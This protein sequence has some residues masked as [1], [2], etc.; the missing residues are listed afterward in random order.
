M[1]GRQIY[2]QSVYSSNNKMLILPW[3]KGFNVFNLPHHPGSWLITL[4]NGTISETQCWS[5]LLADWALSYDCSQLVLSDWKFILLNP[6]ITSISATMACLFINP[7]GNDKISWGKRLAFIHRTCYPTHLIIELLCWGHPLMTIHLDKNIFRL[8]CSVRMVYLHK[9]SS[10]F[11]VT[12][13][14]IRFL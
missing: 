2:T 12:N 14:S 3:R 1:Q 6:C 4:V 11:V 13:F 10:N 9:P 5:L 7:L 8:F